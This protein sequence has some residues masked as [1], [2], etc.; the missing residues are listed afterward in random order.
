MSN[1][2]DEET[3]HWDEVMENFS[4]L[5]TR[6]NNMGGHPTGSEATTDRD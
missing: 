5:F 6:M 1:K 4:L 3:K 2:G